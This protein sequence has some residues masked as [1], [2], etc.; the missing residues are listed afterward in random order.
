MGILQLKQTSS[1]PPGVND[2]EC[3]AGYR[4]IEVEWQVWEGFQSVKIFLHY[5]G[6]LA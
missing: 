5:L 1:L 2:A 3:W 4:G 6:F